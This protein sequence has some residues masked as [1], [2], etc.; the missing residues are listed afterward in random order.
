MKIIFSL[1]FSFII[2]VMVISTCQVALASP[3]S[4][5]I[6]REDK[7]DESIV[8]DKDQPI[9]ERLYV[10]RQEERVAC[11]IIFFLKAGVG[12]I[13]L[14]VLAV[15]VEKYKTSRNPYNYKNRK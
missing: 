2:C 14:L 7:L 3:A 4:E 13:A 10:Y 9:P 11:R 5:L 8:L 1:I 6:Q 15:L 12:L